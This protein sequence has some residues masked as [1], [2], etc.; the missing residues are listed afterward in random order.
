MKIKYIIGIIIILG[1][2][3]LGAISLKST[4]SPYVTIPE[5]MESGSQCQVKGK[6]I[7]GSARFNMDSN[8]FHFT[9][10]DDSGQEMRVVFHGVKPGNFDQ[11]THVVAMGKYMDDH[12]EASQLLIK[13]P[14]KYEAEEI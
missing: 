6:V 5:A 4:M 3:V 9:I 12:F 1:F 13:C 14:S 2:I 8:V 11:A 10:A 7:A